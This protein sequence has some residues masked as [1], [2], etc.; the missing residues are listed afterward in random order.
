MGTIK[1]CCLLGQAPLKWISI[2]KMQYLHPSYL[3]HLNTN[4]TKFGF[5]DPYASIT[6]EEEKPQCVF[7]EHHVGIAL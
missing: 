3:F 6:F 5:Y 1:T 7:C 4:N 2:A